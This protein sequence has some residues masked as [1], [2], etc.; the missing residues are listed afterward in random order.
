MEIDPKMRILDII[1]LYPQTEDVFNKYSVK[2]VD[3]NLSV[4]SFCLDNSISFFIFWKELGL[5]AKEDIK[6]D[7]AITYFSE[8]INDNLTDANEVLKSR[9][10]CISFWLYLSILVNLGLFIFSMA[11][12]FASNDESYIWGIYSIA[13]LVNILGIVLMLNWNRLGVYIFLFNCIIG[14][15]F[16]IVMGYYSFSNSVSM[17]SMSAGI[18]YGILHIKKNGA[19]AWN[20]MSLDLDFSKSKRI[21]IAFVV[22]T[23]LIIMCSI[24]KYIL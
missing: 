16:N 19:S 14:A 22:M 13:L 21:Y 8:K 15:V 23:V 1:E 4:E 5:K 10:G 24:F 20:L 11:S 7:N 3:K 17:I 9:H 6:D 12:L 2:E 18:W